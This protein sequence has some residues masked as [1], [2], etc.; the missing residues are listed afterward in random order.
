MTGPP[1]LHV[2]KFSPVFQLPRQ[3]HVRPS[4][5][6]NLTFRQVLFNKNVFK[7]IVNEYLHSFTLSTNPFDLMGNTFGSCLTV[8]SIFRNFRIRG[9]FITP[10]CTKDTVLVDNQYSTIT[11]G[12]FMVKGNIIIGRPRKR[13]FM[14]C[15]FWEESLAPSVPN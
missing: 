2:V 10:T 9:I 12:K 1:K 11:P 8:E 15:M 6:N 14:T 3:L 13:Y 4:Y 7:I 5:K